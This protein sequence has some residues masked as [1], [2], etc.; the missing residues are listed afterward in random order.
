MRSPYQGMKG[1][2][3]F[4]VHFA[5]FM[6][7]LLITRGRFP[8]AGVY[9]WWGLGLAA[10]GVFAVRGLVLHTMK[11]RRLADL[12]PSEITHSQPP[13][14]A[15]APSAR[16]F[17]GEANG[18]LDALERQRR[19]SSLHP[20]L[21][22]SAL[23]EAVTELHR[24]TEALQ[25]IGD[26]AEL[27]RLEHTREA[28]KE[29]ARLATDEASAEAFELELEAIDERLAAM[30]SAMSTRARL[31]ARQRTLLHQLQS[32]RMAAAHALATEAPDDFDGLKAQ[33]E[34]L[35]EEVRASREIEEELARSRRLAA[36]RAARQ[37]AG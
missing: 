19:E 36:G 28:A 35:H 2:L 16:G 3:N 20:T 10:H 7:F 34:R 24:R 1:L 5:I 4:G 22:L 25:A 17:W 26:E 37:P 18:L 33:A 21:D 31:Q 13:V 9:G 30:Q 29:S 11:G 15:R 14:T 27:H 8:S 32:L 12:A 23:R 6:L